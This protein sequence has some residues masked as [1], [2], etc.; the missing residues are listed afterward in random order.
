MW[1]GMR[2]RID[3]GPCTDW[4]ENRRSRDDDS[5][6]TDESTLLSEPFGDYENNYDH[7]LVERTETLKVREE[8]EQKGAVDI[9][10]V[11][12]NPNEQADEEDYEEEETLQKV[13]KSDT[14]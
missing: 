2:T 3:V 6:G 1:H 14:E 9:E 8:E 10:E 7:E 4:P 12:E 13:R 5:S 11:A